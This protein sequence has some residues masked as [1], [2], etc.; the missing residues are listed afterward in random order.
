M[1]SVPLRKLTVGALYMQNLF[2]SSQNQRNL[3]CYRCEKQNRSIPIDV[4]LRKT[5]VFVVIYVLVK[6]IL[7]QI[8]L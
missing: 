1:S 3:F 6:I 4:L 7:S 8:V 5:H 2:N